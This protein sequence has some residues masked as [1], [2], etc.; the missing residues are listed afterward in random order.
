M[1]LSRKHKRQK[2]AFKDLK[3]GIFKKYNLDISDSDPEQLG[4]EGSQ[5]NDTE[6]G[7]SE[8]DAVSGVVPSG[9]KFPDT[10][11]SE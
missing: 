3:K 2:L 6:Q 5:Q 11:G 10:T 4:G 1:R 8:D 9:D 7:A